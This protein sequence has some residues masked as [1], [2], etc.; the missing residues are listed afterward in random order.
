MDPDG[1]TRIL[2]LAFGLGLLHALDADHI[3]AVSGLACT[4]PGLR[5]SLGFC[6]RWAVGHGLTLLTIGGAVLLLGMAI[7]KDLSHLAEQMVGVVLIAIG[8]WVLWDLWRRRAHLHYH[9][10]DHLPRHAHWHRHSSTEVADHESVS[11][12]HRHGAVMVGVLH[13]TAGSAPLLALLPVGSYGNPWLG[14]AYLVVF[15][16]GV[17]LA[18]LICGGLMGTAFAAVTRRGD[19]LLGATRGVVALGSMAFGLWWLVGP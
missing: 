6:A 10:H 16:L 17:L 14:L 3:M 11:H 1:A 9:E 13:G 8:L 15:G 4:R 7:P 19:G 12:H 18:M 5:T 2:T